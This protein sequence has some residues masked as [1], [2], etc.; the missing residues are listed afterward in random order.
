MVS[1][2][3]SPEHHKA[4][5]FPH[6]SSSSTVAPLKKHPRPPADGSPPL[7]A[8][9]SRWSALFSSCFGPVLEIALLICFCVCSLFPLSALKL[10]RAGPIQSKTM[11]QDRPTCHLGRNAQ[12][13]LQE[14]HLGSSCPRPANASQCHLCDPR[15]SL[16][17]ELWRSFSLSLLSILSFFNKYT[18]ST[19]PVS[20]MAPGPG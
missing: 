18:V 3:G 14:K 17:E 12:K 13:V 16:H 2:W 20:G 9:L 1:C 4:T 6:S 7:R 19:A 5:S 10:L 8:A 11:P 15:V